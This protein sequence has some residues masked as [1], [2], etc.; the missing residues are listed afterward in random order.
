M[1]LV[2]PRG[3]SGGEPAPAVD[4][5]ASTKAAAA[6]PSSAA[7]MP[8]LMLTAAAE[9]TLRHPEATGGTTQQTAAIDVDDVVERAWR[10]LMSRLAIE[11]ERRG[12][13]RWA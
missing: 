6:A 1:P 2:L 4:R 9:P 12:F 10:A 3:T 8:E 11:Q 7:Q 13:G 5:A